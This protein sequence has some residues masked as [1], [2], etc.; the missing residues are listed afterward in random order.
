[1]FSS[2][3]GKVRIL[4]SLGT[5]AAATWRAKQC[6]QVV[7][8]ALCTAAAA[9]ASATPISFEL[10]QSPDV[11]FLSASET[12]KN[13]NTRQRRPHCDTQT[14]PPVYCHRMR[15][16]KPRR[17]DCCERGGSSASGEFGNF[18]SKDSPTP[19]F[20]SRADPGSG[21]GGGGGGGVPVDNFVAGNPFPKDD[22]PHV[23]SVPG[24]VGG[25]G[26]PGLIL[27]A[28]GLSTLLRRRR[29]TA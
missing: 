3:F 6:V 23:H 1:M 13:R 2:V 14:P 16:K 7:A 26:I 29:R 12:L 8:L 9:Q 17:L 4:P 27:L 5:R 21:G 20:P 19:A 18:G 25:T 22:A 15:T 10:L 28:C 24:P 11:V